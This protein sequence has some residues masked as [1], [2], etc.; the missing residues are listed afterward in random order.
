MANNQIN[1]IT[2]N[3]FKDCF[4]LKELD[5]SYN[6]IDAINSV[7]FSETPFLK[8]LNFEANSIG[9]FNTDIFSQ[10]R[11]TLKSFCFYGN[12]GSTNNQL[13]N[14]CQSQVSCCLFDEPTNYCSINACR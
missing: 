1:K 12:P 8:L 9:N 6:R 14:S 11:N 4:N 13:K 7:W 3:A 5:L 2:P 10:F